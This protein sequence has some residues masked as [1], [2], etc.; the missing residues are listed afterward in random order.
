MKKR[1]EKLRILEEQDR[2]KKGDIRVKRGKDILKVKVL[3]QAGKKFYSPSSRPTPHHHLP[4]STVG[5]F[6]L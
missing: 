1:S 6:R 4:P 5:T 2:F 3:V